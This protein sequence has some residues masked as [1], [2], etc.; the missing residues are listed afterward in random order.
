MFWHF[1]NWILLKEIK[2]MQQAQSQSSSEWFTGRREHL[3]QLRLC[4]RGQT[5]V[6]GEQSREGSSYFFFS[7]SSV[8]TFIFLISRGERVKHESTKGLSSAARGDSK[9]LFTSISRGDMAYVCVHR[10]GMNKW[11]RC[12][13][14]VP[15]GQPGKKK[16]GDQISPT[17]FVICGQA[18]RHASLLFIIRRRWQ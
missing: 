10:A 3:D 1:L 6:E 16:S 18:D 12:N 14:C 9:W 15:G 13:I 8:L 2:R 17:R 11:S 7:S 4:E 5:S